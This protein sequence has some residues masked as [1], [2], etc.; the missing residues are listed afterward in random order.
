[1]SKTTKS[2]I[3]AIILILVVGFVW[4]SNKNQKSVVKN[5]TI[6]IG[7]ILPI[8]GAIAS[9]GESIKNSIEMAVEERNAQGGINGKKVEL[10]I[11]DTT[12]SAEKAVSAFNK[13]LNIDKVKY[14]LGPAGSAEIAAVAPIIEKEDAIMVNF[15]GGS[16]PYSKYGKNAFTTSAVF[17]FEVPKMVEYMSEK[18]YR[19]IAFLG[20]KIDSI[21]QAHEILKQELKSKNINL[22]QSEL[23]EATTKDFRTSLLKIK[24]ANPDAIYIHPFPAGVG[25]VLKEKRELGIN[26]PIL[27]VSTFEDPIVE[28][29][30]GA[31]LL[32]GSACTIPI[33]KEKGLKY[34][35]KY[36]TKYSNKAVPI[37]DSAYDAANLLMDAIQK[38][39]DIGSIRT[40]LQNVKNY[41]G[42]GGV[43]S[44][45][46]NRDAKRDYVVKIFE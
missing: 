17:G 19:N 41:D 34:F 16:S 2:I 3:G 36:E 7:A 44:I 43:F 38:G 10:K 12:L 20:I 21:V 25:E 18:G 39:E 26:T 11:E 35:Q 30:A 24:E 6:K 15:G 37:S 33:R 28:K 27:G 14:I 29:I 42:A 4:Y 13:L 46:E 22:V 9:A 23:V 31:E 45:D 40:Y 1:M 8:T 32:K 5:E